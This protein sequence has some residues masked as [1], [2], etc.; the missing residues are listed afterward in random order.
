MLMPAAIRRRQFTSKWSRLVEAP[1]SLSCR[2]PA[3]ARMRF[4]A[5]RGK[6]ETAAAAVLKSLAGCDPGGSDHA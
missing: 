6:P 2:I 4:H 3:A 5:Y 1:M